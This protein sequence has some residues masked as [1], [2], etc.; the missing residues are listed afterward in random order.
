MD[1]V[2]RD[3]KSWMEGAKIDKLT[4]GRD[5]PFYQ[6]SHDISH[7]LAVPEENLLVPE[8]QDKDAFDHLYAFFL[9]YGMDGAGD[10]IPIKQLPEKYNQLRHE[11]PHNPQDED[12]EK[13][14]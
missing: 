9:F 8:T 2:C 1:L 13:D 4:R 7:F 10:F 14:A 11:L 12:D 3:S 6:S 5:Q